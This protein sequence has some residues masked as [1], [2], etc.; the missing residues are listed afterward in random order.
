MN[1][2]FTPIALPNQ[3]VYHS[4]LS[5][6]PRKTSDYSFVNLWGW[7]SA[8]DLEWARTDDLLWLRQ[9]RPTR[10]FWAPVGDWGAVDWAS[11]FVRFPELRAELIRVPEPLAGVWET[12]FGDAVQVFPD[13][14]Q[15]DYLYDAADLA[16]LPG[17]RF[18]K[19]RNLLHQFK[20][21][22]DYQ[23]VDMSPER[24]GA[25]MAMQDNWCVWRE[26]DSD[27]QLA[28]ENQAIEKVL[29]HWEELDGVIGGCLLIK[30]AMAAY[31]IGERISDDT[32]VIHFEKGD[33]AYKGIYQAVNQMFVEQAT[34]GPDNSIR[35]INREQ[36]LGDPG[37]RRAKESYNPAAFLKKFRVVFKN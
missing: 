31:T 8:Y 12:V 28:R 2:K 11:Y 17:N 34:A 24:V 19:K 32:L 23:Y 6:C 10:Q 26:C 14:D 7:A 3:P 36:D 35:W 16:K 18:H 13:R 33:T 37:L 25:A 30:D 22:Y 5:R 4:F 20:K 15:F 1:L 27:L 9:N 21:S 29:S